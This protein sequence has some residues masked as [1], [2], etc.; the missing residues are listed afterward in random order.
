MSSRDNACPCGDAHVDTCQGCAGVSDTDYIEWPSDPNEV[1]RRIEAVREL[2]RMVID[3]DQVG[4]EV[5]H[6]PECGY[7]ATQAVG[8][9]CPTVKAL[10]GGDA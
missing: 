4:N 6:C 9:A 7:I 3:Y 5:E 8:D 10:L 2:H 1:K